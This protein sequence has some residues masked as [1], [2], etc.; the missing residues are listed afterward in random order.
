MCMWEP[1][2]SEG[3]RVVLVY[4]CGRGGSGAV[5]LLGGRDRQCPYVPGRVAGAVE[6][7]CAGRYLVGGRRGL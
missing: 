1:S 3:S 2:S 6:P 5:H 7:G 4:R